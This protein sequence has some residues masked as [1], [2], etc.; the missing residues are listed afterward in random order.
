MP[1]FYQRFV[2]CAETWPESVALEIQTPDGGECST[3][4]QV[5]SLAESLAHWLIS[6]GYGPG[7]RCAILA[8]NHPRWVIT[9]LGIIAAGCVAVPLDTASDAHQVATLLNDSGAS[10]LFSD[11]QHLQ[12]AHQAVEASAQVA[13]AGSE[14]RL[15]TQ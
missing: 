6:S 15:Q 9:Y 8:A 1:I 12:V 3:Y 7:T 2:A 11:S 4:A 10:L 14:S 5:R 13:T